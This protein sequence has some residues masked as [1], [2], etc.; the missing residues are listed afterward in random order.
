MSKRASNAHVQIAAS[1]E[2]TTIEKLCS[3]LCIDRAGGETTRSRAFTDN[4][5]ECRDWK[6]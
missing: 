2:P 5:E 1:G 3:D 4:H 6:A